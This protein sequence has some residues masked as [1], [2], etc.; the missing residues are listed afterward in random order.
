MKCV[1]QPQPLL[2]SW[3]DGGQPLSPPAG[4]GLTLPQEHHLTLYLRR[5]DTSDTITSMVMM[6]MIWAVKAC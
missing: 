4:S 6:P 3:A 1:M 2:L 5:G